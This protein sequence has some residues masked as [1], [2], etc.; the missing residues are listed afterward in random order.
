MWILKD[1][2][3]YCDISLHGLEPLKMYSMTSGGR[4]T[5]ILWVKGN[6]NKLKFVSNHNF[7]HVRN[8][9]CDTS[10]SSHL[11]V[12]LGITVV[13]YECNKRGK[14]TKVRSFYGVYGKASVKKK[15]SAKSDEPWE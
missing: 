13:M 7:I 11:H 5:D 4:Q 3:I 12:H 1:E 8:K 9:E 10:K 6:E 14:I 2:K 15:Q